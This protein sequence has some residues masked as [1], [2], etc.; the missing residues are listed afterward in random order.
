ME[1]TIENMLPEPIRRAIN[2][3]PLDDADWDDHEPTINMMRLPGDCLFT[4][5]PCRLAL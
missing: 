1:T 2:G 4:A 5:R 3:D